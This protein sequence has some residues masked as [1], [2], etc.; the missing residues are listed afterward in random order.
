MKRFLI[1]L[2]LAAAGTAWWWTHRAPEPA[3]AAYSPSDRRGGVAGPNTVVPVVA[4]AARTQ[5]VS[6]YLDGIGTVLASAN[7]TIRSQV[8]GRVA[9]VNFTEGQDVEAGTVLA[10]IDPRAYQ[11][12]VD[13]AVAKKAQD[14]ATLANARLDLARYSKLAANA[15]TSA[16]QADT[17]RATVAQLVAQVAGDQAQIDTAQVN[18][19]YTR[20]VAPIAGRVGIRQVDPGNIVHA[21]DTTGICVITTLRPIS[22][23]F[24]LPQQNLRLATRALQ[25]GHAEVL[26]LPQ[27]ADRLLGTQTV[28]DRGELTVIDNQVDST[29]GTIKLKATFPNRD[30]ALWPGG[31]VNVKLR[32]ET[33]RA[34]LVVPPSAI[35]RGPAGPY[36]YVVRDGNTVQHRKVQIAHQD[37][38]LA[39][40]ADGLTEGER[41]VTDGASRLSEGSKVTVSEPVAPPKPQG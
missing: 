5:D 30:L 34:A 4:V 18:L 12:A 17:A 27:E 25:Q 2:L 6:I 16:Q 13:L 23:V 31:F 40:I 38:D 15:Y 10:R 33:S 8:D 24:S 11:A 36:V 7:V 20:I 28:L 29:T 19:G 21:A 26:A 39:I 22:V 35:Q 32:V 14:E 41:V 1:L 9:E 37:L 3:R